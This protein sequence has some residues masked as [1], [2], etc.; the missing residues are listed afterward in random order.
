MGEQFLPRFLLGHAVDLTEA[1]AQ[2]RLTVGAARLER[3][4]PIGMI[5]VHGAHLDAVL[6]RIAH[7]LGRR[8]ETHGL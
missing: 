6:A 7:E 8:V 3:A 2:R 1:K 4:V 5:D